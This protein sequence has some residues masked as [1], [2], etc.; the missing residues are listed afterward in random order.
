MSHGFLKASQG[1]LK[2]VRGLESVLG[3]PECGSGQG[4]LKASQRSLKAS[5]E[6]LKLPRRGSKMD[7]KSVLGDL[8]SV[9]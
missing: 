7:P 2:R 5:Q 9:S 8:K 4:V 6:V 3:V 1:A